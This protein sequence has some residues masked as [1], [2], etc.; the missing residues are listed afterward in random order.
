[1][2]I[3]A[4]LLPWF[5]DVTKNNSQNNKVE[6]VVLA[7]QY[8]KTWQYSIREQDA[9]LAAVHSS[10]GCASTAVQLLHT[11]ILSEIFAKRLDVL[12]HE[13]SNILAAALTMNVGLLELQALLFD[14]K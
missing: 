12:W 14:Q 9:V 2:E 4:A 7:R 1:M 10:R 13:R 5:I 11:A 8:D 3:T 6:A